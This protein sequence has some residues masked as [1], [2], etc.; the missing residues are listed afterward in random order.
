[1]AY[2][3][4]LFQAIREGNLSQVKYYL[5]LGAPVNSKQENGDAGLF[6]AV[7]F[8]QIEIAKELIAQGAL[9][10]DK[11]IQGFT[12]LI[13]A[14]WFGYEAI[15]EYLLEQGAD[16][17]LA[18]ND[19]MT[20]LMAAAWFGRE[21]MVKILVSKHANI[22]QH[23]ANYQTAV[24]F[25]A[26]NGHQ[27]IVEYLVSKGANIN[28]QVG[29]ACTALIYASWNGHQTT[30]EYLITNGADI[31]HQN[32]EGITALIVAAANGRLAI[33][34]YL[35]SKGANVSHHMKNGWT[36]L[37][38]AAIHEHHA[39]IKFLIDNSTLE[40]ILRF[41]R[42]KDLPKN[43]GQKLP[44]IALYNKLKEISPDSRCEEKLGRNS[45][46]TSEGIIN[47]LKK[48]LGEV[49][50]IIDPDLCSTDTPL[51]A[52]LIE[53]ENGIKKYGLCIAGYQ[54]TDGKLIDNG[55]VSSG[56][57]LDKPIVMIWNRQSVAPRLR[58]NPEAIG[59][60]HWVC[61]IILPKRYSVTDKVIENENVR[62][63]YLDSLSNT[64]VPPLFI[65]MLTKGHEFEG[66][67]EPSEEEKAKGS[68][69]TVPNNQFIPAVFPEAEVVKQPAFCQ[70]EGGTDC[71]WWA[72]Y[73][74]MMVVLTGKL[75]FLNKFTKP[76]RAFTLRKLFPELDSDSQVEAYEK[77]VADVKVQVISYEDGLNRLQ[78]LEVALDSAKKIANALQ[79]Q[80][81]VDHSLVNQNALTIP[82]LEDVNKRL[83]IVE[84][85]M[86]FIKDYNR[87]KFERKI[88]IE[89]LKNKSPAMYDFYCYINLK[90]ESLFV[91]H[92]GGASGLMSIVPQKNLAEWIL[93]KKETAET[94][95]EMGEGLHSVVEWF[96]QGHKLLNKA[97]EFVGSI[98]TSKFLRDAWS[99]SEA[100]VPLVGALIN[101][102]SKVISEQ[103]EEHQRKCLE[104]LNELGNLKDMLWVAQEV[105]YCLTKKYEEVI[106]ELESDKQTELQSASNAGIIRLI[107]S[108][109]SFK[110]NK[111][112]HVDNQHLNNRNVLIVA[113]SVMIIIWS[114]F[115][116]LKIKKAYRNDI[117]GQILHLI[118]EKAEEIVKEANKKG[119]TLAQDKIN[120][121]NN[122]SQV[123]TQ[124]IPEG[125]KTLPRNAQ[126]SGMKPI[127]ILFS[128][129]FVTMETDV[130]QVKRDFVNLRGDMDNLKK[131]INQKLDNMEDNIQLVVNIMKQV[132]QSL[133]EKPSAQHMGAGSSHNVHNN[134]NAT[135][136]ASKV[137]TIEEAI[138]A[139]QNPLLSSSHTS[140]RRTS[141]SV[142]SGIESQTSESSMRPVPNLLV[143]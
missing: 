111:S 6:V 32:E 92:K 116:H 24:M 132:L 11:N 106:K 122:V 55:I 137:S 130:K 118:D 103:Q 96:H 53:K 124:M 104:T 52:N 54:D 34:K 67:R 74:A 138:G 99:L 75:E 77:A 102:A 98:V 8:G 63:I 123:P 128:D 22:N 107:K 109:F 81:N 125:C 134:T 40:D 105:A 141:T 3:K 46:A 57:N 39:I 1:M 139:M 29:A 93:G 129:K 37:I 62:I 97:G 64:E 19:G 80:Q 94:A 83:K 78:A 61:C 4:E 68:E 47:V 88:N 91:G 51:S 127:D 2:E 58:S 79:A 21:A 86:E 140:M 82:V 69:G 48:Y 84:Q 85:T 89:E 121:E 110:G 12:A 9:V 119:L 18:A 126:A 15:A 115:N 50:Y 38:A 25:A 72:V 66:A 56:G 142:S 17:N 41:C 95:I 113:E 133:K 33:V 30:V 108:L 35:V 28:Q 27:F 71:G 7:K 112:T 45:L 13:A 143:S 42:I 49:A 36:A 100:A 65:K 44:L 59:G 87:C 135:S 20:P 26:K 23:A 76:S 43:I 14:A 10:D 117:V 31:N 16:I 5:S 120:L 131:Y 70:Q 73:N 114:A 60:N 136:V 90:L 101:V